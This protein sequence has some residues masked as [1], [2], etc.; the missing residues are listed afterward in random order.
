MTFNIQTDLKLEVQIVALGNFILGV[1][2]LG[3]SDKLSS[4]ATPTWTDIAANVASLDT[5]IGPSILSGIY[6]QIDPGTLN[7]TYQSATYDP[8]FNTNMRV[9]LPIRVSAKQ[10][11]TW[12]YIFQG[13]ISELSVNYNYDGSNIVQLRAVDYLQELNNATIDSFSWNSLTLTGVTFA[14]VAAAAEYS[15]TVVADSGVSHMIGTGGLTIINCGP[16]LNDFVRCELGI[17]WYSSKDDVTYFRDRNYVTSRVATTASYEF[18]DVHSTAAKHVCFSDLEIGT[19]TDQ[20]VNRVTASYQDGTG[21]ITRRNKDSTQ[22]YGN[23]NLVISLP[24]S[25]NFAFTELY[26]W[27]GTAVNRPMQRNVKTV[28]F[29]GQNRAGELYDATRVDVGDVVSVHKTIGSN[30]IDEK[31]MVTNVSHSLTPTTWQTT[32]ELWK[33]L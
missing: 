14:A 28:T 21:T 1:S 7:V 30:T 31:F 19:T 29:R 20:L 23:Y 3:G 27:I 6:T 2:T 16:W 5:D 4:S 22:L 9:G 18:S 24:L 15:R 13:L 25:D 33:G 11:G 32:L 10:N 26:D 17:C 12:F 8:N